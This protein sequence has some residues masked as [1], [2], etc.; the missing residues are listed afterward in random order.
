MAAP[1]SA[2]TMAMKAATTIRAM[3]GHRRNTT[4]VPTNAM[5]STSHVIGKTPNRRP[6]AYGGSKSSQ[7]AQAEP[8]RRIDM[9]AVIPQI[10]TPEM[11]IGSKWESTSHRDGRGGRQPCSTL[12]TAGRRI[13]RRPCIGAQDPQHVAPA[14]EDWLV[15]FVIGLALAVAV[16]L[17]AVQMFAL[18]R[19]RGGHRRWI[20]L[21][22]APAAVLMLQ[23]FWPDADQWSRGPVLAVVEL[24]VGLTTLSLLVLLA[25]KIET[26]PSPDVLA[27]PPRELFAFFIWGALGVPLILAALLLVMLATGGLG[28]PA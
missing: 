3:S 2:M 4:A 16:G 15:E 1:A 20:Y 17:V 22:F 27:D 10:S 12:I 21:G 9:N 11:R 5:P 8:I 7:A 24:L 18:H 26:A 14:S 23:G 13:A 28:R 25:R 6:K 19:V